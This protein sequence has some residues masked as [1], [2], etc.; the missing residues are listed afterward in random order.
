MAAEYAE[1]TANLFDEFG[2]FFLSLALQ[3]TKKRFVPFLSQ[4]ERKKSAKS[5]CKSLTFIVL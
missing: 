4:F 3:V 5:V 2:I 1:D